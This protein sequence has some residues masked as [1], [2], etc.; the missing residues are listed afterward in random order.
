MNEELVFNPTRLD[1]SR[2]VFPIRRYDKGT[3]FVGRLNVLRPLEVLPGTSW[4]LDLN[5]LLRFTTPIYPVNDDLMCDVMFY[6]TSNDMLLRRQS[7]SPSL[8]DGNHSFAAIMG[9]QDK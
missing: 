9:A 7:F 2:S 3:G 8:N 1:V 4:D 6:Y 5:S